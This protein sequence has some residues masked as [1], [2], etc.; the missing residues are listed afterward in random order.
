[1]H[2]QET[3]TALRHNRVLYWHTR[4][5]FFILHK[6]GSALTSL[7][8][9]WSINSSFW[10]LLAIQIVIHMTKIFCMQCNIFQRVLCGKC[11]T[12]TH[13][14]FTHANASR[15]FTFFRKLCGVLFLAPKMKVLQKIVIPKIRAKWES[16]AYSMDYDLNT[17]SAIERESRDL[18]H[19]CQKLFTD[20]L[21]T[22]NGPTPKTWKTLLECIEDVEELTAALEEIK[23]GLVKGNELYYDAHITLLLL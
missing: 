7:K 16:V 23:V 19:C 6:R 9:F 8:H 17:I 15:C 21:T 13:L 22:S 12:V 14:M 20:W 11:S 2:R 10:L 5:L 4:V 1:M 3:S 18:Q